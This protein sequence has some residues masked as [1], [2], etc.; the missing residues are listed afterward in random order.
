MK[1]VSMMMIMFFL[2]TLA[3]CQALTGATLGENID[4]TNLTATVKTQLAREKLSS[5]TRIEV[6]TVRGV[7]SLNG[8]V[9]SAEQKARAEQIARKVSG[10]KDV[11][12][13]LQVQQR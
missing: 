8:V 12:N 1:M 6:D 2:A 10:V 13:N 7:V 3:G 5:L 4:D 9:E 11:V